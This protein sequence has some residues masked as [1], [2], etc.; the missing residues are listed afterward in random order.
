MVTDGDLLLFAV[1]RAAVL[2]VTCISRAASCTRADWTSAR[3]CAGL[4]ITDLLRFSRSAAEC[5]NENNRSDWY[6]QSCKHCEHPPFRY[7]LSD[8]R[9]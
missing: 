6:E 7:F 5:Q 1:L 2:D 4:I 3:C 9:Y 8:R